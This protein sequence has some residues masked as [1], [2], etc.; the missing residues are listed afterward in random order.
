M[1]KHTDSINMPIYQDIQDVIMELS[2][3]GFI[4]MVFDELME[5][6]LFHLISINEE[7]NFGDPYTRMFGYTEWVSQTPSIISIGWDWKL[8]HDDRVIDIVRTGLPRSNLMLTDN[9][10]CDIGLDQTLH[11]ISQ[12]IDS[13]A[14]E[15]IVKD[16]IL[17]SPTYDHMT[18][19]YS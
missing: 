8:K 12:K 5:T 16:Q 3:D 14:W 4:R 7:H 18:F 11:L 17:K 1:T 19:S 15:V 2:D 9:L 10:E 6:Q 13:I